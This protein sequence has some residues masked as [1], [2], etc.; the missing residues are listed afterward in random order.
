MI[1]P[2]ESSYQLL[3][4]LERARY[5]NALIEEEGLSASQVAKRFNKSLA[6]VSN[7]LRLLK[8]SP[9][10]QEGLEGKDISEGHARA[11][12]GAGHHDHVVVVYREILVRSI[13]VRETERMVRELKVESVNTQGV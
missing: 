10:V 6:F 12:L 3:T 11:L 4:P 7:T 9:L 1:E 13:S 8:L 5:F 2:E